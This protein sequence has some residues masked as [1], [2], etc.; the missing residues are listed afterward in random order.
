MA[1]F[2]CLFSSSPTLT[3]P[4]YVRSGENCT[5]VLNIFKATLIR[6]NILVNLD[7]ATS[8]TSRPVVVL[9]ILSKQENLMEFQTSQVRDADGSPTPEYTLS[10]ISTSRTAPALHTGLLSSFLQQCVFIICHGSPILQ[11]VGY[12]DSCNHSLAVIQLGV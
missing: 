3:Y 4:H 11:Y 9:I 7:L 6:I 12:L 8:S 2:F 1:V 5:W 10:N